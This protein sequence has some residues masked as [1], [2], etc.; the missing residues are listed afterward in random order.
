MLTLLIKSKIPHKRRHTT[1]AAA[2]L[3]SWGCGW[4][5]VRGARGVRGEALPFGLFHPPC[6][7]SPGPRPED[8]MLTTPVKGFHPVCS[9]HHERQS[10]GPRRALTHFPACDIERGN[11]TDWKELK[12]PTPCGTST[13]FSPFFG[14]LA[15]F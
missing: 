7:A 15:L 6:L 2:L 9:I 1:P 4:C 11:G 8:A 3:G 10:L 13:E 14:D 5:T 12:E